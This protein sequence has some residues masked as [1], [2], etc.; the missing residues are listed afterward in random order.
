MRKLLPGL[1]HLSHSGL[2]PDCR[3]VGTSLDDLVL[4]SSQPAQLVRCNFGKH[5]GQLWAEIPADYLRWC[6]GQQMDED[7][8]HTVRA[9]LR[10]RT[11][12][13]R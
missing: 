6:S 5:R 11:E 4:I 3:I 13:A 12:G 8:L 9:E 2:V 10:R 7:T 1:M